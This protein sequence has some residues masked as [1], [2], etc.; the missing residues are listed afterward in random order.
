MVECIM[1]LREY[2]NSGLCGHEYKAFSKIRGQKYLKCSCLS[3]IG[4]SPRTDIY[5]LDIHVYSVS[6]FHDDLEPKINYLN[7]WLDLDPSS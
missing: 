3:N 6:C 4:Q 1:L 7:L 5:R 2:I